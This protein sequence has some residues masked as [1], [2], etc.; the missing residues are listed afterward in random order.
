MLKEEEERGLKRLTTVSREHGEGV[1]GPSEEAFSKIPA[2][3]RKGFMHA[4]RF[5]HLSMPKGLCEGKPT[6]EGLS[7]ATMTTEETR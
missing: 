1:R 4:T 7:R 3:S 5:V 2:L 6:E